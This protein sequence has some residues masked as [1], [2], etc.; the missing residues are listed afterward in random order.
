MYSQIASEQKVQ[1]EALAANVDA[2]L[3]G[4]TNYTYRS[5]TYPTQVVL[6]AWWLGM[7]KTLPI[8]PQV[9][10]Y[11]HDT[12]R[13]RCLLST[14]T[15]YYA[16]YLT[17]IN[18]STVSGTAAGGYML[19]LDE[20]HAVYVGYVQNVF[21]SYKM[22]PDQSCTLITTQGIIAI[23]RVNREAVYAAS[24]TNILT[25]IN[26]D[27]LVTTS[28]TDN[29]G[30]ALSGADYRRML[31]RSDRTVLYHVAGTTLLK[32]KNT[33]GTTDTVVDYS[34][35]TSQKLGNIRYDTTS[36]KIILLFYTALTGTSGNVTS[37]WKIDE[38]GSNPTALISAAAYG[39]GLHIE[40][41]ATTIGQIGVEVRGG[42]LYAP[43]AGSTYLNL[44]WRRRIDIATGTDLGNERT[45]FGEAGV[46]LAVAESEAVT[47]SNSSTALG[48]GI[49][50]PGQNW[51]QQSVYYG[52]NNMAGLLS[53]PVDLYRY[54]SGSGWF[55]RYHNM[56]NEMYLTVDTASAPQLGTASIPT[57]K[58]S[59]RIYK[60]TQYGDGKGDMWMVKNERYDTGVKE[61]N[62]DW[63]AENM[64]E[65][66]SIVLSFDNGLTGAAENIRIQ[67]NGDTTANY[68]YA[69]WRNAVTAVTN[70]NGSSQT[71]WELAGVNS[72]TTGG[73]RYT[74]SFF[75]QDEGTAKFGLVEGNTAS[76]ITTGLNISH[77]GDVTHTLTAPIT[78]VKIFLSG[79]TAVFAAGTQVEVVA[80]RTKSRYHRTGAA[81]GP[82]LG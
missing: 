28:L 58:S 16:P 17:T 18:T 56:Q 32:R 75:M 33:N 27:T 62:L 29:V 54:P 71:Y 7:G 15:D 44:S 37:A 72:L 81:Y 74:L 10:I 66:G 65:F 8:P 3:A 25:R 69:A 38:N 48:F 57:S 30:P 31:Q 19:P 68:S 26:V 22:R 45:D 21:G 4:S 35:F 82:D 78:S 51:T 55:V 61:I 2:L 46:Q 42:I 36:G 1:M 13:L 40:T 50:R 14:L 53:R 23:D 43:V 70:T 5:A 80:Y 9:E 41:D 12:Y 6:E 20:L 39:A 34:T 59:G 49:R 63:S 73:G 24:G 52:V 67:I 47:I 11:W 64:A 79:S 60:I 76:G 77:I